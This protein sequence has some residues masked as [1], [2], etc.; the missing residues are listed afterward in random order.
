VASQLVAYQVVPRFIVSLDVLNRTEHHA[1]Q[2]GSRIPSYDTLQ[3]RLPVFL[4]EVN[5]S[6]LPMTC[7]DK[8]HPMCD[9][10]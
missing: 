1:W 6:F 4:Q 8:G 9:S 2:S 7:V 10:L 5:E 3:R